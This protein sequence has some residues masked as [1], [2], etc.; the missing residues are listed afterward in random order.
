MARV[1]AGTL[2][3][4]APT[5]AETAK[6]DAPAL[7]VTLE[8]LVRTARDCEQLGASVIHV[9]IRDADAQPTLDLGRLRDTVAE[10]GGANGAVVQV[11]TGTAAYALRLPRTRPDHPPGDAGRA[12]RRRAPPLRDVGHPD[13]R[14]G[15]A[16]PRQRP[17]RGARRRAGPDRAAP[18]NAGGGG[19]DAARGQGPARRP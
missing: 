5:G 1:A 2:L 18:A 8:E 12:G 7:P 9:H 6:S 3:T 15:R 4:V 17:A 11:T 14:P 19:P 13:L 16:G 10:M